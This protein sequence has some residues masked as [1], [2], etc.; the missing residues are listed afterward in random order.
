MNHM[1]YF[2]APLAISLIVHGIKLLLDI[3]AG[4]FSWHRT[5]HYGGMPSS[6][7]ALVT[8]LATVVYLNNGFCPAFGIS[9]ILAVIVIRD[10]FGF[11]GYISEHGRILNK[12]VKDLPDE[13]EYKYPV[14]EETI[15]HTW[16]QLI[17]GG[18]LGIILTFALL[19]LF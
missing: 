7:A 15:A 3:I 10:A 11:R 4:R 16:T 2:I 6:H 8:S 1:E 14:V 17:V 18:L 12:L 19:Q 9:V 5:G 13:E